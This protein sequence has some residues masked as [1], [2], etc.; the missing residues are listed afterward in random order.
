M[1]FKTKITKKIK[2]SINIY[3]GESN[4]VKL[5]RIIGNITFNEFEE[6]N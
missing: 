5:N 2:I 6:S 4:Y 1:N 3:E